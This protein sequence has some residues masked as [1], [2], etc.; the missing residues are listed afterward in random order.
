MASCWQ[1]RLLSSPCTTTGS[2]LLFSIS[3]HKETQP[4][5]AHTLRSTL[6]RLLR[7]RAPPVLGVNCHHF[8]ILSPMA[9][10]W[11]TRLLSSP[12]TATGSELL[13]SISA[14][15]ETQPAP[16]HTLR[17]TLQRRLLRARAPPVLGVTVITSTFSRRWRPAGRLDCCPHP[18]LLLVL[19]S[20]LR[21][22]PTRTLGSLEHTLSG[23]R[24]RVNYFDLHS[25]CDR[26]CSLADGVLLVY[27]TYGG[28]F[29]LDYG[30]E[31]VI[32]CGAI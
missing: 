3:A 5:P 11:Q 8:N 1:T 18:A 27:W 14:H 29:V 32:A 24:S 26:P 2:E 10:C 15:K 6:Q 22:R 9:S 30:C 25:A 17:S 28:A 20:C 4:A 19:S 16:A 7:A 23:L 31:G 12:C 13:F 21:F